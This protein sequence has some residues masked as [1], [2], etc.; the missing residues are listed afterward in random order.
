VFEI[1]EVGKYQN[2]TARLFYQFK[3][4]SAMIDCIYKGDISH[5]YLHQ[6][7]RIYGENSEETVLSLMNFAKVCFLRK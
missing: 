7:N 2:N 5:E 3:T 6:I 1:S 4:L